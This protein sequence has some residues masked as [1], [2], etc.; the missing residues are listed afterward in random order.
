M[1]DYSGDYGDR[2]AVIS[3]FLVISIVIDCDRGHCYKHLEE[4]KSN[5]DEN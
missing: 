3:S 1:G 4:K 2:T 5:C